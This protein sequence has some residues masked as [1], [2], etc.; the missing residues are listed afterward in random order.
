MQ[1]NTFSRG[2][3]VRGEGM[4]CPKCNYEMGVLVNTP[5][6]LMCARCRDFGTDGR[7]KKRSK[8][9]KWTNRR[10]F[11]KIIERLGE[12]GVFPEILDYS[13]PEYESIEVTTCKVDCLGKLS[14]GE[15][16]GIRARM[17]LEGHSDF[18]P[19]GILKTLRNDK[20]SWVAMGQLMIDFQRECMR[21]IQEHL[22][23][24]EISE[25]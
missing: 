1:G 5:D 25:K 16:E 20:E 3:C 14:I 2:R 23:E 6:G 19:L 11:D 22:D 15:N 13:L 4:I 18:I 12:K 10:L 8:K 9:S 24:F 21:F 7:L 17:Y